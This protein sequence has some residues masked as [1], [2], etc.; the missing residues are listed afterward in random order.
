MITKDIYVKNMFWCN[1]KEIRVCVLREKVFILILLSKF[2]TVYITY[3]PVKNL[4]SIKF[5]FIPAIFSLACLV[6][7]K[8]S[9]D[10]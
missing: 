5:L 4:S 3:T 2:L 8:L 1:L 10:T 7:R 9:Q 6:E